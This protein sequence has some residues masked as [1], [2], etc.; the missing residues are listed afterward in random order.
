MVGEDR[1]LMSGKELRRVHVIRQV[2]GKQITQVNAGALLGLT[3][4]QVRRLLRRVEQEGDEGLVHRVRGKPSNRRIPEQ[5]K[6]KALQ[7]YEERYGDFGPTLA[8]EKL[9]EHHGITLSDETLRLWL[10][11]RGIEHFR[12][13]KRPH[14]AW[15]AR[16][17]HVGELVQLDGSHHDWLEERGPQCVLMAYI[18]DASSRVFARFYE[19]EGTI[20]AMDSFQRYVRRYGLP[21]ALYADKHTT[22]QSPA[23]P[24]VKEQLAGVEP[25]S[26]F[27]RALRELGVELIAAHSPQAKGRMERLFQTF[28]D[29]LVK[30]LR[31]AGIATVEDTNRFVEHYLPVY[32]RRFAVPPAQAADLHRPTPPNRTLDGSLCLKTTRCL[33]KDFTIVHQGQLYQMHDTVRAAHVLVEHRLDGTLRL[34]H[35]GRALGFHAIAARPVTVAEAKSLPRS[36]RPVTPKP[37]HPWRKRW[38][39]ERGPHPAA[40]GT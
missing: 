10:R 30:E 19:Y 26:Q 24:T 13:R 14:R 20:P 27:G 12:R 35:Q 3:A 32:N 21:L 39:Q 25:A 36:H 34:T 38:R 5:R 18:D 40:A 8:A 33:R 23:E 22:Y 17:T 4:R 2:V 6:A 31:L 15:R 7:L 11:A 29:R 28:Q 9:A 1:V 16:K 37:N